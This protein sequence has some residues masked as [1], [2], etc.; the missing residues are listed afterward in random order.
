[1]NNQPIHK[2]V[3]LRTPVA[4]F[5][6]CLFSIGLACVAS[7]GSGDKTANVEAAAPKEEIQA[8]REPANVGA[9]VQKKT[10]QPD[11]EPKPINLKKFPVMEG[12]ELITLSPAN[13]TCKVKGDVKSVFDFQRAQFAA[14]GWKEQS[15]SSVTEQVASGAFRGAGFVISASV[16]PVG[17]PTSVQLMLHNHGSINLAQLPLPPGTKPVY[18]GPLSAIYATE[19]PLTETKETTLKLLADAG[20]EPHGHEGDSWHYKQGLNRISATIQTEGAPGKKTMITYSCELMSGDL[21]APPDAKD[22]RYDDTSQKLTFISAAVMDAIIDFYREKLGKTGWKQ[23]EGKP[24]RIDDYDQVTYRSPEGEVIFLKLMPERDGSR[25]VA[26]E[27]LSAEDIVEL[28]KKTK[29]EG[30]RIRARLAAEKEKMA[31]D[32]LNKPKLA[33]TIPAGATGVQQTKGGLK[34]TVPNGKAKGTV[35]GWRKQLRDAG[36]KEN[37]AALDAMAGM[38][39]FS[40][41]S[42][43][44]SVNYTDTGFTPAEVSVTAIGIELE[45]ADAAK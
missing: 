10:P 42:Q 2:F 5:C 29:E 36:W 14:L 8:E 7:C 35:E 11:V 40:K 25:N 19:A 31:A 27:Y 12:G 22:V 16:Y 34:C 1:M 23:D 45:K 24:F 28:K 20:W 18:V 43:S 4:V 15:D 9:S 30:D 39:S 44:V 3:S 33:I 21:P 41:D 32:A 38:A 13:L 6:K 26:L 37:A 17:D